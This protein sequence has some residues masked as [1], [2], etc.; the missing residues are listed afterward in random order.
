MTDFTE[1]VQAV[2]QKALGVF[3]I[4][5]VV[6]PKIPGDGNLPDTPM[7]VAE[8]PGDTNSF[9]VVRNVAS[10][11]TST[12]KPGDEILIGRLVGKQWIAFDKVES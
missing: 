2:Q 6:S 10:F 4:V 7:K 11:D 1:A 8:R 12:V 3:V 5:I 9:P